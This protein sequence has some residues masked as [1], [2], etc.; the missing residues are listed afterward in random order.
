[1]AKCVYCGKEIKED[2]MKAMAATREFP[3]CS[4]Q[5][6]QGMKEYVKKDR[7]YKLKMYV[8]I[9]IGGCGFLISA[10][11]GKGTNGMLVAYLGQILAGIAFLIFP[12]PII[13]FETF[14]ATSIRTVT[15]ISKVVG[16]LL[17][18]WG[19]VLLF[20]M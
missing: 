3:V 11:F 14:E 1:M 15:I 20:A 7:K 5:C 17:I 8:M 18:I 10:L 13:S 4:E 2:G 6:E 19:M 9:M 16:L 12:Y